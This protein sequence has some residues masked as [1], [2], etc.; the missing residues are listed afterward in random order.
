M[1]T[2][3]ITSLNL[4]RG[5]GF[6]SASGQPDIFFHFSDLADD[7]PFDEALQE[8]RVRFDILGTGK[9]PQAINVRAAA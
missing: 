1:Y 4:E 7:L 2:G 5:F 6:I 8:R 9:G 3:V